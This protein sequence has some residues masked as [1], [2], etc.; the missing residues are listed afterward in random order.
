MGK[1]AGGKARALRG[2]VIRLGKKAA[3]RSAEVK[4]VMNGDRP[5]MTKK[6]DHGYAKKEKRRALRCVLPAEVMVGKKK[7]KKLI[8]QAVIAR[9]E[10]TKAL[11]EGGTIEGLEGMET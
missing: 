5:R 9:N 7:N 10:M 6:R 3:K 8:T 11:E 1:A 2:G 4:E